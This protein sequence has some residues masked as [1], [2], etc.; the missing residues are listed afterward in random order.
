MGEDY[1]WSTNEAEDFKTILR[2]SSDPQKTASRYIASKGYAT[3]F[4]FDVKDVYNNLDEISQFYIGDV[5]D[6]HDIPFWQKIKNGFTRNDLMSL[7]YEYMVADMAGN[8]E[9]VAELDEQIKAKKAE[10]G[11]SSSAIPTSQWD[12]I[13]TA[14]LENFG[15]IAQPTAKGSLA[16]SIVTALGIATAS[17][18]PIAAPAILAGT[19]SIATAGTV[20]M[21][22]K[23]MYEW[24]A[25]EKYYSLMNDEE[26]EGVRNKGQAYLL[27]T[28]DGVGTAVIETIMD[29][30]TSRLLGKVTG[31]M[32][33]KIGINTLTDF[34]RKGIS[35]RI[36]DAVIEWVTGAV[37]EGFFNE[38]PEYILGEITSS[39][40]KYS[41]GIIDKKHGETVMMSLQR[42]LC[43]ASL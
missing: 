31:K 6:A 17:A 9:R 34:A 39:I 35:N 41:N 30:V 33:G 36:A 43:R 32:L 21:A 5:Y 28:I 25:G 14:V 19:A 26:Y 1:E 2:L 23:T 15:Y 38:A 24:A 8:T 42:V 37:D 29:G 4:G 11:D 16:S 22:G 18:F 20:A 7:E 3:L 10:L 12:E 27:A 13:E 40:Y